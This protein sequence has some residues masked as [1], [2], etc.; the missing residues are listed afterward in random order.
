MNI[1]IQSDLDE[2]GIAEVTKGTIDKWRGVVVQAAVAVLV[3]MALVLEIDL[4]T[5]CI[6]IAMVVFV[7]GMQIWIAKHLITVSTARLKETAKDGVMHFTFHFGEDAVTLYNQETGGHQEMAYTT[8]ASVYTL[9]HYQVFMS[10]AKTY[11]AV[12]RQQA[13]QNHLKEYIL[14]KNPALKQK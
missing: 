13:E 10:K 6:L 4:W 5:R 2:K 3:L 7:E 9:E 11:I 12:D 1:D 8:F 14:S